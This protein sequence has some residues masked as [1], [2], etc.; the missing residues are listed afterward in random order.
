MAQITGG[1]QAI[2]AAERIN[3][4]HVL[5]TSYG[6]A[7]AQCLFLL[8]PQNIGKLVFICSGTPQKN[9]VLKYRL[10][11][12]LLALLPAQWIHTLLLWRKPSFLSGLRTE[13][14]FWSAYY[15][16]MIPSL[17][18]QDYLARLRVWIDFHQHVPTSPQPGACSPGQVLIIAASDDTV[19]SCKQLQSL[20]TLYPQAQVHQ[21][22]QATH[23]AAIS[24]IDEYFATVLRFL[25]KNTDKESVAG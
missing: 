11:Y 17:S 14:A 8:I 10:C 23:M 12:C 18:K 5:G 4:V 7:I 2:L 13:S 15:D 9:T 21:C 19:F 24:N 25:D 22:P 1:L 20:L 3:R 6:G 16:Q